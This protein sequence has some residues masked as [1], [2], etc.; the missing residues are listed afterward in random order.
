M[1]RILSLK[2][3]ANLCRSLEF[4][5]AQEMIAYGEKKAAERLAGLLK[6]RLIPTNNQDLRVDLLEIMTWIKELTY[7]L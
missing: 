6:M 2:Y 1:R 5:R 7:L 3:Q 4:D